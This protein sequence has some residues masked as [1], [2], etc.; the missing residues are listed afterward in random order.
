MVKFHKENTTAK[1]CQ[2]HVY[3]YTLF[4]S[5]PKVVRHNKLEVTVVDTSAWK[6]R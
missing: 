3:L 2:I 1:V 4:S 6:I 5:Q